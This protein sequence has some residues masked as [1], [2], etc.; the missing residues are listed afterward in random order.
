MTNI[1]PESVQR[2][3]CD[4]SAVQPLSSTTISK[5][6]TGS[7]GKWFIREFIGHCSFCF[8]YESAWIMPSELFLVVFS[9]PT[10]LT[11]PYSLSY[12]IEHATCVHQILIEAH[13]GTRRG[14]TEVEH[15]K[16]QMMISLIVATRALL[17]HT[18]AT[19]LLL[20]MQ[21]KCLSKNVP[22][23]R[24]CSILV[25]WAILVLIA[26]AFH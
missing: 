22:A 18:E 11:V 3:P 16:L 10:P 2:T 25:V 8:F 17:R 20:R 26:L 23:S 9:K 6:P 13:T 1:R 15:A 21:P 14:T 4:V 19:A 12:R 7:S 24:N 5:M